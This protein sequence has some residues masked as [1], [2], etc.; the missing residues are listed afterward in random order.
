[1]SELPR[2]SAKNNPRLTSCA[3]MFHLYPHFPRR[4]QCAV[5]LLS[6][7]L[8]GTWMLNGLAR[9]RVGAATFTLCV[10]ARGL[11]RLYWSGERH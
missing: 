2:R 1:M 6:V 4:A 8:R 3:Q 9:A 10:T 11:R 7:E 5:S